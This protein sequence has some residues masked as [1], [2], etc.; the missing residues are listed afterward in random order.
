[1]KTNRFQKRSSGFTLVELMIV[2]AILGIL[3]AVAFPNYLKSRTQA[4]KQSCI[5]NLSQIE[6][7]KQMWGMENGKKEGDV[8]RTTDLIGDSSYIKRMPECGGG[9][10]YDFKAIGI[11]ATCTESGHVLDEE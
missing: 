4:R 7:A 10:T 6:S 2:V 3:L 8:P 5:S 11:T 9:G 1:M